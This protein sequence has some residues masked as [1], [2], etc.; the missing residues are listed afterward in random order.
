MTPNLCCH[1]VSQI[2]LNYHNSQIGVTCYYIL[3]KID[4]PDGSTYL[5][6]KYYILVNFDL[7]DG[8]TSWG[9]MLLYFS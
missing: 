3:V 1:L 5:G 7:P 2:E 6:H 8:S 4:S 9:Y